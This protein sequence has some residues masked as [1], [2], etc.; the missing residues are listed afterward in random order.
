MLKSKQL[1]V[2]LLFGIAFIAITYCISS[3]TLGTQY[4][5]IYQF[6]K[7]LAFYL[8]LTFGFYDVVKNR[9]RISVFDVDVILVLMVIWCC[10]IAY[11][12]GGSNIS[13]FVDIALW[14]LV[15]MYSERW[16]KRGVSYDSIRNPMICISFAIILFCIPNLATR[17]MGLDRAGY[18]VGATYSA[19]MLIPILLCLKKDKLQRALIICIVLI[20]LISTK[21]TGFI[22]TVLALLGYSLSDAYI[23]QKR[24][25]TNKIL[26]ITFLCIFSGVAFYL[27]TKTMNLD[28]FE[29]IRNVSEDQGSGRIEIWETVIEGFKSSPLSQKLF[30]HGYHSVTVLTGRGQLAHNDFLETL[31]DYG[32]V[33]V[34]FMLI[35][36]LKLLHR[37][38]KLRRAKS[39]LLPVYLSAMILFIMFSMFSYLMVQSLRILFLVAFLGAADPAVKAT[40]L[41]PE[42]RSF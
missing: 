25:K 28:I 22:S 41:Y 37:L 17:Y 16:G 11:I 8:V 42:E 7:L 9:G 14:P 20:S 38:K 39:T 33:G 35:F 12:R 2:V 40:G 15:F 19:T 5:N 21:R 13:V 27:F 1:Y 3:N 23:S 24:E 36:V 10:L 26:K 32:I 29:R 4:G 30:G 6:S 18:A 34:S 31:Y